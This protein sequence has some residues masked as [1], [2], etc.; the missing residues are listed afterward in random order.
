MTTT[1]E[2]VEA[3]PAAY[4]VLR[5]A[6][7]D[8]VWARLESYVSWRWTP[9]SVVW[10]VEG[11]GLW[12]APLAP[13][14]ISATEKWDDVAKAFAAVTLDASPFDGYTL[15]GCGPFR[16]TAT[17]GDGVTVPAVVAEAAQR[18]A[19]YMAANPGTPGAATERTDV[20]GVLS[21]EVTRLPSWMAR[22]LQNSGAADLLRQYRRV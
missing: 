3:L 20:P 16:F 5:P 13:A 11:P 12:R 10:T 18:L 17:V 15:S 22:A 7:P 21:T 9:R 6:V 14:T 1:L 2:Q 8:A 4:P 19:S